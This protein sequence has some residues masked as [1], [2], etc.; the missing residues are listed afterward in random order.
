VEQYHDT[1]GTGNSIKK[2]MEFTDDG[3]WGPTRGGNS[4]C[5]SG[6][7]SYEYVVLWMTRM[8]IGIRCDNMVEFEFWNVT[9]RSI[10]STRP[11]HAATGLL[12]PH[13]SVIEEVVSRD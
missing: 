6:D 8:A 10:D 12:A 1:T 5:C 7:K 13:T 2:T 9:V 3:T 11:L 4:D